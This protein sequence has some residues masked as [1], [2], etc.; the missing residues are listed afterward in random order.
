[1]VEQCSK[2]SSVGEKTPE[3]C[4]LKCFWI[5]ENWKFCPRIAQFLHLRLSMRLTGH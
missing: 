5:T 3:L 1:M 4:S 2:G